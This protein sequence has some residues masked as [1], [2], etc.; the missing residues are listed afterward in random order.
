MIQTKLIQLQGRLDAFGARNAWTELEPL[1][2]EPSVHVLVDLTE[3]RYISSDGL[4]VLMRASRA[5]K[6]NGGKLVL[7]C[8]NTRLTE[9][10]TMA[11]LEHV[12]EIHT[13]RTA[14]QRALDAHQTPGD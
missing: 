10:V 8:L 4:R 2:R 11:G 7:C 6:T 9:I 13:N 14:A 12:L 5:V 1:T 3:T